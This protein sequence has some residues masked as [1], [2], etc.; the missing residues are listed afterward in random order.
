MVYYYLLA[1]L[2][3]TAGFVLKQKREGWAAALT[4]NIYIMSIK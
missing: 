2:L 3:T 1:F 4:Y